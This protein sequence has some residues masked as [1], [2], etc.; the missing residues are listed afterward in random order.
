MM[1]GSQTVKLFLCA[2]LLL[3]LSSCGSHVDSEGPII[4]KLLKDSSPADSSKNKIELRLWSF[5]QSR[6]YDFWQWL[7]K[8]YEAEHENISIKV[9]FVTSDDYFSRTRLL[10]SFA[11]GQGPDLFFVSPATLERFVKADILYPLTDSFTPEMKIDFYPSALESVSVGGDIYA[12]PIETELLGLFYNKELF[13]KRGIKP[14]STWQEMKEAAKQLTTS[15]VSGL[16]LETFEGVYL[17]FSWL[18]FLW[19]TGSDLLTEDGKGSALSGEASKEMYAFFKDMVNQGLLNMRPSRP[20]TDIGII[21]NGET[22]MQVSGTWNIRTLETEFAD[23]PIGVVP[24]PVPEGG[25]PVTIAGGWK[26][27]ANKQSEHA[28]EAAKF[29]MWA[30]T[31]DPAIPL[32]WVNE[33]KFAYSPRKSVMQAGLNNYRQGL[34]AVFTDQI[35]GTEQEEPQLPEEINRIFSD[36]LQQLLFSDK[37]A[38]QIQEQ[39]DARIKKY[40][41]EVIN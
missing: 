14:P 32:K 34:R 2:V 35:F 37:S 20:V 13:R 11:S 33:V 1:A 27:A 23:Q 21:A 15:R 31:G 25:S 39:A 17:N 5:H 9:E 4:D 3:L 6:E 29:I 18:P 40:L 38:P 26:L 7:A 24:L 22:A 10:S 19:Q 16:T 12:V 8:E 28:E 36:S 41:E 30:L